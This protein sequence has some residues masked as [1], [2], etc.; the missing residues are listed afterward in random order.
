MWHTSATI[1]TATESVQG[2]APQSLV[3]CLQ[4]SEAEEEAQEM[5][6]KID[7]RPADLPLVSAIIPA[8]NAAKFIQVA[9]ESALAQTHHLLEIIVVDDGSQDDTAKVAENYSVTVIRQQNGGPA[10]ARNTGVKAA[11]GEWLA[12]LDHDD[13]WHAN[14]TEQQLKYAQAGISAVFS[15]KCSRTDAVSFA[16]MFARNYGGNLSSTMIRADVLRAL[17]MFDEDRALIGVDDYN[18]WLRFLIGGYR[19]AGTP[20][21]YEYTPAENHYGGRPDRMLAAELANIDKIAVLANLDSETVQHRKR[22]LRL[23]YVPDLI[24]HRKLQVARR[25]LMDL[26]FDSQTAK[27][28]AV[29]FLPEWTLNFRRAFLRNLRMH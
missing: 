27:Y 15:E 1:A 5:L 23:E 11:S 9:I 3:V 16:D 29:A 7:G 10:S 28:W 17:G 8:Y 19:F 20:Q 12:F 25:H 14:K 4:C 13:S 21:Y 18:F 24:G 26:G 22:L 2:N 6:S